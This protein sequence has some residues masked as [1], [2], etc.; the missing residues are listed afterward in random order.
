MGYSF[1]DISVNNAFVDQ[2]C[3][4]KKSRMII[5]AKSDPV[6]E[7]IRRL[8]DDNM[9]RIAIVSRYFGEDGF[10]DELRNKLSNEK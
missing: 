2:I 4:N 5:S 1:R 3:Y 7:R 8:F 6:K 9:D 10:I